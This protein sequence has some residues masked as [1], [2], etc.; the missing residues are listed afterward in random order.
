M[1]REIQFPYTNQAGRERIY[2]AQFD[3]AIRQIEQRFGNLV[4]TGHKKN[5]KYMSNRTCT[6]CNGRRLRPEIY[7]VTI[8]DQNIM[9]VC[10]FTISECLT[11][12]GT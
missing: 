4:L 12:F 9:E 8:G 2:S 5:V 6:D 10:D 1:K 3:S 11:F 7:G